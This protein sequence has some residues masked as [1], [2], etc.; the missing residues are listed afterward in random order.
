MTVLLLSAA[1]ATAALLA[2]V[3][4]Q[5][6]RGRRRLLTQRVAIYTA[7]PSI[8]AVLVLLPIQLKLNFSDGLSL[9]GLVL[10][11]GFGVGARAM[12][13]MTSRLRIGVV[14]PSSAPFNAELRAGLTE[15]LS[16]V[17]LDLYDDYLVTNRAV[18][19]LSEFQPGLRRTLAWRPD[20]LVVYSPSVPLVSTEQVLTLIREFIRRGGGVVFI[21][22][23][24][25]EDVRSTLGNHYGRVTSDV[26]MG[27][28]IIAEY[29]STHMGTGDEV[30]VL[31]GPPASAPA[32]LRRKTLTDALP[33]ATI[34]VAD[35]GGWTAESAYAATMTSFGGGASPRFVVCGNDVMA[36]GAVRA[37]R[38]VRT[39]AAANLAARTEVIGYDGIARAL[40]SIAEDGNPFVAT[41]STPPAAYGHEVASMILADASRML[42]WRSALSHS[43]IPVGEG[44]LVT[45]YNI[46]LV[47]EG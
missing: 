18:E 33:G 13:R 42:S 43:V 22:N 3:A 20:Y 27:A 44:Q 11:L 9:A 25:T 38:A 36:F 46:N 1:V 26:E 47:L 14:I 6:A 2:L 4:S 24:P 16:S 15:A 41:L 8:T 40:F 37:I 31:S 23:E 29:V 35:S 19:R 21:D 5:V 39:G 10:S 7:L 45:R 34:L 30:L 32:V 28:R 17:R 12:E